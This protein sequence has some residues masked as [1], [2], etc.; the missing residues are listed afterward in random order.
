MNLEEAPQSRSIT[1]QPE[2][3]NVLEEICREILECFYVQ[4]LPSMSIWG[5]TIH[6]KV[7]V[8]G[9]PTRHVFDIHN[10]LINTCRQEGTDA[11]LEQP[12]KK[13]GILVVGLSLMKY[14]IKLINLVKLNYKQKSWNISDIRLIF[15]FKLGTGWGKKYSTTTVV[16]KLM[17]VEKALI[18]WWPHIRGK[19]VL[20]ITFALPTYIFFLFAIS[21]YRKHLLK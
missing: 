4:L 10:F 2:Y 19:T 18:Y 17:K 20:F 12:L 5:R 9:N 21:I 7:H 3:V 6:K 14:L 16:K 11:I 8:K 15:F 13:K 1:H